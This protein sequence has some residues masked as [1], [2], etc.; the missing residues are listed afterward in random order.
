M[1]RHSLPES[2]VSL[3]TRSASGLP[4]PWVREEQCPGAWSAHS[5]V[6]SVLNLCNKPWTL[7]AA[8]SPP[9]LGYFFKVLNIKIPNVTEGGFLTL[10]FIY[11]YLATNF[12]VGVWG[13]PDAHAFQFLSCKYSCVTFRAIGVKLLGAELELC[14]QLALL[15]GEESALAHH[16]MKLLNTELIISEKEAQ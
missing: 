3:S 2:R 14:T 12:K 6:P 5:S 11:K 9:T 7:T 8:W 15:R 13:S 16:W 1:D 4:R 10:V